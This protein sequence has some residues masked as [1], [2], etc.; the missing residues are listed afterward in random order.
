MERYRI[1]IVI[2]AYNEQLTIEAVVKNV[3]HLGLVIVVDD[4]S[5]DRTSDIA[6]ENGAHLVRHIKN[7]GYEAA[8]NTGFSYAADRNCDVIATF[9]ADG[10]HTAKDLENLFCELQKGYD[11]VIG[12]RF[13]LPR[14]SERIFAI[15]SRYF[16]GI[17]D[18]LSGLKVYKTTLY[19]EQGFF[20]NQKLIGTQLLRFALQQK[21]RI[22]EKDILTLQRQDGSRFG[23]SLESNIKILRVIFL[24]FLLRINL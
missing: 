7:Q 18:P 12:K 22:T 17:S 5:S 16:W 2:P 21:K 20:D 14:L 19:K 6:V 10:Q 24:L 13:E 9:D 15:F 8:L 1:A 11:L 4:G 23:S 3:R